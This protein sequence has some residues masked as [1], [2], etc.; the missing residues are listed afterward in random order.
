[1]SYI[2]GIMVN[3][4]QSKQFLLLELSW[5]FWQVGFNECFNFADIS[6][7][8]NL[9]TAES[10]FNCVIFLC[11]L[12]DLFS[13]LWSLGLAILLFVVDENIMLDLSLKIFSKLEGVAVPS[14]S[15]EESSFS[16]KSS[17]SVSECFSPNQW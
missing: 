2:Y 12:L 10:K 7:S 17:S 1:M 16:L 14:P 3:K 4:E 5:W 13:L 8:N 6:N 15:S 9:K 11:A